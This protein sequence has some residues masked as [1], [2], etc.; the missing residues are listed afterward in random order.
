MSIPK[1]YD[2]LDPQTQSNRILTKLTNEKLERNNPYNNH[3]WDSNIK[4]ASNIQT[5]N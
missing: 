4:R 2:Y 1:K 3:I 5:K